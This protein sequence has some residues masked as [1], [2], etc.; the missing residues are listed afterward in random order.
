VGVKMDS[1][2]QK[3]KKCFITGRIGV[4]H[5]HH[6]YHGTANRKISEDNGFWVYLIPELHNASNEGVHC[7]DGKLLDLLLKKE[8][9]KKYE[10][11]HTREQFMRLIGLNYL[12]EEIC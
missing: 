3:E 5:K 11:T 10:Q 8:C 12:E 1:I 6:I 9:Q 4:L 2:L 7:K